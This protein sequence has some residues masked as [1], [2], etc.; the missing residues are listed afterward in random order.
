MTLLHAFQI[1]WNSCSTCLSEIIALSIAI[2]QQSGHQDNR[3]LVISVCGVIWKTLYSA[4]RLPT[5]LN[6]R[7]ALCNTFTTSTLI[8]SRLLWNM[9]FLGFNMCHKNVGSTSNFS[10]AS[11]AKLKKRCH[12]CFFLQFLASG[13]LKTYFYHPMW[14]HLVVV[15]V[16]ST[17]SATIAEWLGSHSFP[18]KSRYIHP[19]WTG[20]LV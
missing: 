11:L 15:D 7:Y 19:H 8:R 3:I 2:F 1:Q 10:W 18:K 4:V 14:R 9:L 13:Q 12:C 6:W 17:K 5:Y 20:Q 16:L